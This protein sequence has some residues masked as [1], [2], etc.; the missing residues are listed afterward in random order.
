MSRE[1]PNRA[2]RPSLGIAHLRGLV[3]QPPGAG[4]PVAS[5]SAR[6]PEPRLLGVTLAR[7]PISRAMLV[8]L[9]LAVLPSAGLALAETA[10]EDAA[11]SD[12]DTR[13]RPI[14]L[15]D[16]TLSQVLE[17]NPQFDETDDP[18]IAKFANLVGCWT[19][20]G[21]FGIAADVQFELGSEGTALMEF[22]HPEK[23]PT[24]YTIYYLDKEVPMAHHFCSYG[25]Q[26]RMRAEPVDD[27]NVLF[28]RFFDATNLDDHEQN[29]MTYVRYTFRDDDHFDVEWGL[30][31]DGINEP[32]PFLF[33]RVVEGCNVR[34]HKDW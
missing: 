10:A 5:V 18:K 31:R 34:D 23:N 27:P 4:S 21:P 24:M 3:A 32:Q 20:K 29:H 22:M 16:P 25:S 15:E 26:V 17:G 12:A 11:A 9:L 14:P 6:A 33:K 28:F 2:W 1:T 19:G 30:Q 13:S 8:S 7:G